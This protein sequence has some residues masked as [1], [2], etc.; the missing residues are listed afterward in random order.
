MEERLL[1]K[2]TLNLGRQEEFQN[3]SCWL[4]ASHFTTWPSLS[5]R[6]WKKAALLYPRNEAK[7]RGRLQAPGGTVSSLRQH[8]ETAGTSRLHP[9]IHDYDLLT[10][11]NSACSQPPTKYQTLGKEHGS[12]PAHKSFSRCLLIGCASISFTPIGG[13]GRQPPPPTPPGNPLVRRHPQPSNLNPAT[14]KLGPRLH[15][16]IATSKALG[17]LPRRAYRV[18]GEQAGIVVQHEPTVLPPLHYVSPFTQRPFHDGRH[19]GSRQWQQTAWR[20][21]T[22]RYSACGGRG[23][24]GAG[25]GR[26]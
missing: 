25:P 22:I 17:A 18:V 13:P 14:V 19:L 11:Y 24:R 1:W 2:K 9:L 4:R 15:P 6:C 8:R 10:T 21:S 12:P 16:G 5:D 20:H 23:C 26:G 7:G 3:L